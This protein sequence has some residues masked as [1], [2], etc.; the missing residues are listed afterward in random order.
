MTGE[1]NRYAD[2]LRAALNAEVSQVEPQDRFE[3]IWAEARFGPRRRTRR[4]PIVAVILVLFLASAVI[5]PGVIA[6]RD[7]SDPT[8]VATVTPSRVR[9]V[10]PTPAG[11][12]SLSTIQR[13]LPVFYVSYATYLPRAVGSRPP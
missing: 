11:P 2:D 7:V 5:I 3:W 13:G 9:T 6:S 1:L 10:T 8:P 4:W 12:A